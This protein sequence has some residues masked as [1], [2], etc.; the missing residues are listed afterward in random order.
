MRTSRQLMSLIVGVALVAASCGADTVDVAP[1]TTSTQPDNSPPALSLD[2]TSWV[3]TGS[4][5]DGLALLPVDGRVSTLV[6]EGGRATGSTGCNTYDGTIS[7]SPDGTVSFSGFAVTEIGCE[8]NVMK[9]ETQMLAV[10]GRVDR[11]AWDADHLTLRNADRSAT[12]SMV[13]AVVLPDVALDGSSWR[14]TGFTTGNADSMVMAG[15]RPTLAIDL[16]AGAVRGNGGC[17]DFGAKAIFDGN[18]L[19]VSDMVYTEIACEEAVM[20]QEADYFRLLAD[21]SRWQ[22]DGTLLTIST[23]DGR[24]LTLATEKGGQPEEAALAWI[25]A[26]AHGDLDSAAALMASGSLA[27][28]DERGGLAAFSTELTEGWGAWDQVNDRRVWSVRGRF[29]DGAEGTAVVLFGTVEQEGMTER[30]AVAVVTVEEDGRHLVD[31]FKGAGAIGFVVPRTDFVDRIA[32]DVPFE[33]GMPDGYEVI[34]FLDHSS[35]LPTEISAKANDQVRVTALSDPLPQPGE[36]VLT[37]VYL[38]DEGNTG[39]QAVIFTTDPS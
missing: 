31:P 11:F 15:T 16:A 6:V 28:V 38:D 24:A 8:P 20:R 29:S 18:R 17:N 33:L 5:L 26:L 13:A 10:L 27:Y 22:I 32:P 23:N 9:Y 14:L 1:S 21:A 2:G 7:I 34:I 36:H 25:A 19:I 37:V 35:A 12:L 3:V 39:A 4:T 30:G